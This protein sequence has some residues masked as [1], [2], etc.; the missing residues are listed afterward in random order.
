MTQQTVNGQRC[1][2]VSWSA[3]ATMS[4]FPV[5]HYGVYLISDSGY[6]VVVLSLAADARSK[7][8]CG[9]PASTP[10]SANVQASY[11]P[12]IASLATTTFTSVS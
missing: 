2:T 8:F 3:P 10:I 1:A 9:L 12:G 5:Q 4:G 7:Q 11:R 6:S